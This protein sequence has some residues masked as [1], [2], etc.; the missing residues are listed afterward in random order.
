[1]L[2]AV[3]V[4]SGEIKMRENFPDFSHFKRSKNTCTA[5]L[6]K[7]EATADRIQTSSLYQGIAFNPQL[8]EN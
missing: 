7:L 4:F 8:D 2:E 6:A 5:S 1:M 3:Q